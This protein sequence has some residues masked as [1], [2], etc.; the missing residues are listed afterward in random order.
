[1]PQ[2][3]QGAIV[4]RMASDVLFVNPQLPEVCAPASAAND[5]G[6]GMP[7]ARNRKGDTI[8]LSLLDKC[9]KAA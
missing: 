2:D 6:A 1:M 9:R 7:S 3:A 5:G 4:L 8:D